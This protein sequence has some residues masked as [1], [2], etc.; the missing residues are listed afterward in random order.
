M[1]LIANCDKKVVHNISLETRE[2]KLNEISP[3]IKELFASLNVAHRRGY[4]NCQYCICKNKR[5]RKTIKRQAAT[6]RNCKRAIAEPLSAPWADWPYCYDSNE[7]TRYEEHYYC[8][9]V[10]NMEKL[11]HQTDR[12]NIIRTLEYINNVKTVRG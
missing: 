7:T 12:Q 9:I 11:E 10:G 3:D 2:C 6:G 1:L 8:D 4:K 5:K